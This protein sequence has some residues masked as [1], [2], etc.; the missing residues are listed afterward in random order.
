MQGITS[1]MPEKGPAGLGESPYTTLA[2]AWL[3][4]ANLSQF[5]AADEGHYGC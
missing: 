4:W 1:R 3:S 5:G 2:L